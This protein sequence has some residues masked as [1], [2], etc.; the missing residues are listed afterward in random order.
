MFL[1]SDVSTKQ[2]I[3]GGVVAILG[4]PWRGGG[5][6]G[7]VSGAGWCCRPSAKNRNWLFHQI[8]TLSFHPRWLLCVPTTSY[9]QPSSSANSSNSDFSSSSA[10]IAFAG[11]PT[12]TTSCLLT[13]EQNGNSELIV[14]LMLVLSSAWVFGWATIYIGGGE[15]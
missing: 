9:S 13:G 15:G 11:I 8:R 7:V 14:R 10:S 3:Q 4:S 12:S 2:T 6:A 1:Y 5:R